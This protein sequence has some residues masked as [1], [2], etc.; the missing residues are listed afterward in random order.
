MKN[1][2]RHNE[3]KSKMKAV[4]LTFL[5]LA[6]MGCTPTI[7]SYRAGAAAA[8]ATAADESL[9]TGIWLVCTGA[10]VGAVGRKFQSVAR[11]EA[12]N[13]FCEIDLFGIGGGS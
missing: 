9:N 6:V 5:A 8:A 4:I 11:R 10:S 12:Y 3:K 2:M 1:S 13:K 7:L